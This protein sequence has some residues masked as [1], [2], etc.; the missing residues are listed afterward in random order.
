MPHACIIG[1][2]VC[3]VLPESHSCTSMHQQGLAQLDSLCD[4]VQMSEIVQHLQQQMAVIDMDQ[5]TSYHEG[6]GAPVVRQ[7]PGQA[8]VL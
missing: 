7:H 3:T 4:D 8:V 5:V 2:C 1:Q 6:I